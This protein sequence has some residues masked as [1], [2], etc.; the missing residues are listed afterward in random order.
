[1]MST[2]NCFYQT[3]LRYVEDLFCNET[4]I[5]SYHHSYYDPIHIRFVTQICELFGKGLKQQKTT[6]LLGILSLIAFTLGHASVQ[7]H[8]FWS[9][10][11]ILCMAVVLPT[12]NFFLQLNANLR[13]NP[14]TIII[15][16]QIEQ[17]VYSLNFG[18][19]VFTDSLRKQDP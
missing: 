19:V 10:P 4:A 14:L 1:M 12:G 2:G 18:S 17:H 15:K 11:M 7:V 3:C 9:E 8:D 6:V 5:S 13:Y 16:L